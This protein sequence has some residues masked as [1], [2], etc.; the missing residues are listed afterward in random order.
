MQDIIRDPN[1]H[2]VANGMW[3]NR[4]ILRAAGAT[5]FLVA[6]GSG[7]VRVNYRGTFTNATL[8]VLGAAHT[9]SDYQAPR[10]IHLFGLGSTGLNTITIPGGVGVDGEFSVANGAHDILVEL[11]SIDTGAIEILMG[12]G[13]ASQL[14][15]GNG[16]FHDDVN[17]AIRAGRMYFAST[18]MQ[19][20]TSGQ[21]LYMTIQ[22]PANSGRHII[23][24]RRFF[25]NNITTGTPLEYGI[26]TPTVTLTQTA[27]A[28]NLDLGQ[29]DSGAVV[30]WQAGASLD[31]AA[32]SA[33]SIL[34]RG[35]RYDLHLE[36][37]VR[38]G[39]TL[40]YKIDGGSQNIQ[41]AAR[42]GISFVWIEEPV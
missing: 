5:A 13:G 6:P 35:E 39:T 16:P 21:S 10:M 28:R 26:Y 22:N 34:P 37:R 4:E 36:M 12:A 33:G 38:S 18:A 2:R 29:P 7:S 20:V 15:A 27:V 9:D 25:D 24:H 3:A 30:R 14:V 1:A 41:Q 31:S 23:L 19:A 8:W 17:L 42:V 40:G 11:V 32:V